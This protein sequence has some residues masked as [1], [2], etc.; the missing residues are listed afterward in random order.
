MGPS[1]LSAKPAVSPPPQANLPP[2]TC[3]SSLLAGPLFLRGR[4]SEGGHLL[5]QVWHNV[6]GHVKEFLV[7]FLVFPAVVVTVEFE[8][9]DLSSYVLHIA[10]RLRTFKWQG[11][12]LCPRVAACQPHA[13]TLSYALSL[14]CLPPRLS[15]WLILLAQQ[16][17]L[18]AKDSTSG[19]GGKTEKWVDTQ[20]L[21]DSG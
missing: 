20:L 4:I 19:R 7:D 5:E 2:C 8:G 9:K 16:G 18:S 13:L 17:L 1:T 11:C 10:F 12:G 15:V 6:I 14:V 21:D 3:L